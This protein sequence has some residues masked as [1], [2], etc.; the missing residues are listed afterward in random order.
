M[1]DPKPR[2]YGEVPTTVE[3]R[4]SAKDALKKSCYFKIDF[5]I[6]EEA[7]VY[8]AVQRFAAYN[9]GALAVTSED[10]KVIGIVSERDYVSKVWCLGV[11]LVLTWPS[12]YT[13]I[14]RDCRSAFGRQHFQV[15]L[16]ITPYDKLE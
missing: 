11:P 7:T 9:I 1:S 16:L 10:Q 6:D 13:L 8:E 5:G 14:H 2:N 15:K 4:S 3:N 12:R